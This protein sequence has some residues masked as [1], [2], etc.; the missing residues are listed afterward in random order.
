M[1][2]TFVIALVIGLGSEQGT[3]KS[4]L[5]RHRHRR[6]HETTNQNDHECGLHNG[7]LEL[8]MISRTKR[9]HSTEFLKRFDEVIGASQTQRLVDRADSRSHAGHNQLG[10][11]R[12]HRVVLLRC[13]G[14]PDRGTGGEADERPESDWVT[15]TPTLGGGLWPCG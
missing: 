5:R 4:F 11:P 10:R 1:N 14:S 12:L 3:S 15:L 13:G 9:G 8:P 6:T 2:R 7:L